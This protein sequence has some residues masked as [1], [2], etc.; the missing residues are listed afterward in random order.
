MPLCFAF[1]EE[2]LWDALLWKEHTQIFSVFSFLHHI[3]I[4]NAKH[5][6]FPLLILPQLTHYLLDG[7]IWRVSKGEIPEIN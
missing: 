2:G 4:G 5:I 6:L 7:F 1:V 3:Q